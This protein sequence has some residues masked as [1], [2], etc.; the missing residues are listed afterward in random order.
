MGG[1]LSR[2]LVSSSGGQ[3]WDWFSTQYE[4]DT[5]SDKMA[6]IRDRIEPA[7][8]FTPLPGVERAIFIAAPHRGTD[9]AGNRIARWFSSLIRLPLTVLE[10]FDDVA[11][12][13][14]ARAPARRRDAA[15]PQQHRQP[16][17]RRSLRQDRRHAAD[18]A[19][20]LLPLHHRPARPQGAPGRFRR[21]GGALPQRPRRCGVGK[22]HPLGAQRAGDRRGHPEIRRILHEDWTGLR[23]G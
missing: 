8:S 17:R 14:P 16:Q 3:L 15:H 10:G 5:D 6:A 20:R 4:I 18:L 22:D 13:W 9:I 11:A 23:G 1:V 12:R 21:R 19:A 7:L 2:L